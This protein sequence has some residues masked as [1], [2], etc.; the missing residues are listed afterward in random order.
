VRVGV[1]CFVSQ[2]ADDLSEAREADVPHFDP[3]QPFDQS[4]DEPGGNELGWETKF[5][6]GI[7][8]TSPN[9]VEALMNLSTLY[10]RQ[11][12]HEKGLAVDR[13]LVEL[14][15]DDP[16]VHYNLA[17]SLSLVTELDGALA[18]LEK[19]IERGYCDYAYMIEDADLENVR[20]DRRFFELMAKFHKTV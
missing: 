15:P 17:C 18:E 20:G 10:T 7:V 9:Y 19:A 12:D 4:N 16:I 5:F 3:L 6:E 1:D 8:R 2:D 14:R 11:G 13:R